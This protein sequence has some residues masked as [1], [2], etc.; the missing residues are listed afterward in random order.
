MTDCGEY[1]TRLDLAHSLEG[2]R[3]TTLF[4][5]SQQSDGIKDIDETFVA[6]V[7]AEKYLGIVEIFGIIRNFGMKGK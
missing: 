1:G 3:T 4:T 2:L 6:L 7:N 5:G